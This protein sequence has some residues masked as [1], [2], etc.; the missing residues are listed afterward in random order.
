MRKIY[1]FGAGIVLLLLVVWGIQRAFRPHQNTASE[2]AD[3]RVT[4]TAL[5]GEFSRDETEANKKWIGRVIEVT[6]HISSVTE[7]GNYLSVSLGSGAGG[8]VI[9]SLLKTDLKAGETPLEGQDVVIK[10][11]CTG[12][13]MD[14]TLVD[15]VLVK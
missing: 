9:C 1:F 5:Y 3:A 13:L 15:C 8:G 6:G 4:A 12:Y 11:K 7:A 14:V 2:T 10:G